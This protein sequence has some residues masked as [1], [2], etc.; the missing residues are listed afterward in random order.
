MSMHT[1]L[2]I[3]INFHFRLY[4][5]T[6]LNTLFSLSSAGGV[7]PDVGDASGD[8]QRG[9]E[10]RSASVGQTTESQILLLPQSQNL[11]RPQQDPGGTPNTNMERL[12]NTLTILKLSSN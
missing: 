5:I 2:L 8:L 6:Y 9:T 4:Y 10:L 11:R 3:I 12:R 7:R 1:L